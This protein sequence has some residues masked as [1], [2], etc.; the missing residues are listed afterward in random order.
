MATQQ[1]EEVGSEGVWNPWPSDDPATHMPT[2]G[3]TS[4]VLPRER[5]QASFVTESLLRVVVGRRPKLVEKFR[6]LFSG[7]EFD[8]SMDDYASYAQLF[9]NQLGRAAAAIQIIRDNPGL[10]V[11]HM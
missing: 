11:A 3:P 1:D 8:A 2:G 10:M 7:P 4:A 6:E 5:A 9:E